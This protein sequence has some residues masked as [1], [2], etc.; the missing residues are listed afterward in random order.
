MG[1]K[2]GFKLINSQV[3]GV[4]CASVGDLE[5]FHSV[6]LEGVCFLEVGNLGLKAGNFGFVLRD[7]CGVGINLGGKL[8]YF[9]A[10]DFFKGSLEVFVINSNTAFDF[11]VFFQDESS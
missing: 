6:G 4:F 10:E 1:G 9:C 2:G 8:G 7:F 11:L 5:F 3:K